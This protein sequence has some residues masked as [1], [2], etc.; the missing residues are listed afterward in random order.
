MECRHRIK[1]R[2]LIHSLGFRGEA[3]SSVAAV[4]QVELITKREE[5]LIGCRYEIHGGKEV[6]N[7]EVGCPDASGHPTSSFA[8]SLPP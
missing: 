1:N 2:K 8:T 6:A 3:L 5:D 7:E 4:A